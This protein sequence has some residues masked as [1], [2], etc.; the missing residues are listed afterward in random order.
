MAVQIM[1]HQMK[2][3]WT[4]R[5]FA[6][7]KSNNMRNIVLR[8]NWIQKKV[9]TL[10][11]FSIKGKREAGVAGGGGGG[12]LGRISVVSLPEAKICIAECTHLTE[13]FYSS[14]LTWVTETEN[15]QLHCFNITDI[16]VMTKWSNEEKPVL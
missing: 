16:L 14:A 12:G 7:C 1:L 6:L 3:I 15:M 13:Q 4:G 9:N 10:H 11:K 2:H 5:R 8:Q